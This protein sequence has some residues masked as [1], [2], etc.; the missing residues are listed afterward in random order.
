MRPYPGRQNSTAKQIFNY[1]LSRARRIVENAFGVD[2]TRWH[3]FHTKLSIHPDRANA[4]VRAACV[5]HNYP[6]NV[7]TPA[8]VTQLT[9]HMRNMG[10]VD[11]IANSLRTGNRSGVAALAVREK[12]KECS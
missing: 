3:V 5:L 1:R 8:Q 7:S 4:V 2:A 10:T 9:E 12:F 6:Q 11:A